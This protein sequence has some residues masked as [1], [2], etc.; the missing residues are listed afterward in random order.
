MPTD[1]RCALSEHKISVG[2]WLSELGSPADNEGA[3]MGKGGGVNHTEGG[4]GGEGEAD[5]HCT[6]WQ[7]ACAAICGYKQTSQRNEHVVL[8]GVQPI[9][10]LST[11]QQYTLLKK[12]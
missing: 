5:K 3:K 10:T 1:V 2:H 11:Y 4:G 12:L 8:C 9:T 7:A 6:L